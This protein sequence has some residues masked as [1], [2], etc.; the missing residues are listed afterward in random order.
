MRSFT[1]LVHKGKLHLIAIFQ[2]SPG[3]I[4]LGF[5]IMLVDGWPHFD[6]FDLDGLLFFPRFARAPLLF[7]DDLFVVYDFANGRNGVGSNLNQIQFSFLGA[8]QGVGDWD[9]PNLFA[10]CADQANFLCPNVAVNTDV[11]FNKPFPPLLLRNKSQSQ[12]GI[13]K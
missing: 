3:M 4:H 9:Q 5:I 12:L 8:T 1:A 11:I 7:V 13:R 10:V 2:K 6:F